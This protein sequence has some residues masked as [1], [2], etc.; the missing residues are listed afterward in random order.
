MAGRLAHFLARW[1]AIT[2]DRAI[3]QT[4]AGYRLPFRSHPP[5]QEVEPLITMSAG[6]QERCSREIARLE[7]RGAI[8]PVVDCRG[9]FLSPFFLI[10][11][12]SGGWRFILNLK[13]LNEFI[14]APH[15]KLEDWKTVIRLISPDDFLV[16]IDLEEAYLLLPI[17]RADRKFLRFRFQG[18]LFQFTALPFGLA[19]VPYIFTKILKPVIHCLRE[20]GFL[21]VVYLDDFLLVA[22]SYDRSRDNI[23]TTLQLLSDLGFVI[24]YS[25][26][27][28]TPSKSCRFLGFI[29][30][31]STFSVSIP[32]DKRAKLITL[33]RSM[34][35][36]KS[37]KIRRFASF[38]GSLVSVCPAV[39]Y[40][41]LHTKILEREKFLALASAN[42]NFDAR[43][44]LP[45]VIRDDLWWWLTVFQ[46]PSQ[47][48]IIRSG[49]FELEIFTDA[50]LTGWGAVCGDHSTHGFWSP[51]DKQNHINYL[52]L[53]A[54][55]HGLRCFALHSRSSDILLRVDNA[56]ALSYVNRMGSIRFPHLSALARDIWNWCADRDLFILAAYI[57][58][59]L[60]TTA[61]V[62][63][64][65]ISTETEWNLSGT[66]FHSIVVCLGPFDI[67]LFASS[68]NNK[69]PRFVSWFPDPLACAVDAFSLD[70]RDLRF[71]AFLPF[72]LILRDLRKIISDKAEG[73]LVVPWWPAQ[74][75]FPL[76]L[77]L[78][79]GQSVHF[80]PDI[81][82]LSSPF[83]DC[84][85]A[86]NRI[87]LVAARLSGRHF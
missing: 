55:F 40:G 28:L 63:S 13:R 57:P 17:H 84:H 1:R 15:F 87:S 42:D 60:N 72:I 31:T 86:W 25:K 48:N 79:I 46:D 47:S 78:R 8:E 50:S 2:I 27:M 70:W 21:C 38:I 74:P 52:E 9:Q 49:R 34:L 73:I 7:E 82:M 33:T 44:K 16:S 14:S 19:S 51:Q 58:S 29:F 22:N 64:R 67:D 5:R 80:A 12:P 83:S 59:A 39:K 75:W 6:E 20:Q 43:M 62:E 3:L 71:Y 56:T 37:C 85:P 65:V 61:D 18:H 35:H 23:R 68:V 81:N 45:A 53:L 41:M 26:S 54:V 77:Q 30:D 36:T 10:E 4:I 24:N 32:P 11:K 69:C 66:Y 76:F